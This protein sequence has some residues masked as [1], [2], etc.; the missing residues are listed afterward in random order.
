[1]NPSTLTKQG[2]EL[3][4]R[5]AGELFGLTEHHDPSQGKFG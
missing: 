3:A 4:K 5:I 1:M 2:T